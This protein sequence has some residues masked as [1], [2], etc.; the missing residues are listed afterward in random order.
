MVTTT[1]NYT[2]FAENARHSTQPLKIICSTS[3]LCDILSPC[4]DVPKDHSRAHVSADSTHFTFISM[5]HIL[6]TPHML[7]T[8]CDQLNMSVALSLFSN[9]AGLN[10]LSP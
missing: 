6:Y 1:A 4:G 9:L 10:T 7:R 3:C 5:R 2:L 8:S